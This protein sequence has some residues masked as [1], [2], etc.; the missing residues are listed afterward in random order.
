MSSPTTMSLHSATHLE[1][2]V[3]PPSLDDSSS[4][5]DRPNLG[6]CSGLVEKPKSYAIQLSEFLHRPVFVKA[7]LCRGKPKHGGPVSGYMYGTKDEGTGYYRDDVA[8][9]TACCK[10]DAPAH[11]PHTVET[12]CAGFVRPAEL[13]EGDALSSLSPT[14][15]DTPAAV[16]PNSGRA[17]EPQDWLVKRANRRNHKG[18]KRTRRNKKASSGGDS[19]L[20]LGET[21]H[22]SKAAAALGFFSIDSWNLNSW[23]A[24]IDTA[25]ESSAEVM[26]LQEARIDDVEKCARAEE[27]AKALGWQ[28]TIS[29]AVTTDR[30]KASAGVAV[31]A[32]KHIGLRTSK[33]PLVSKAYQARLKVAWVNAGRKGGLHVISIYCWTAEGMTERNKGLLTEVQRVTK[34]LKGPGS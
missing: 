27:T 4:D 28:A 10:S 21:A 23:Y 32:K 31:L 13:G 8:D 2:K 19:S 26:L 3:A 15:D 6:S 9:R 12:V 11:H 7:R 1:T 20:L 24:G 17:V 29:R 33:A 14:V 30:G 5:D 22:T 16:V 34:L 25:A 18:G